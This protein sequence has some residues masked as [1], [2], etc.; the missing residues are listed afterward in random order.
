TAI[1]GL[2][3][4]PSRAAVSRAGPCAGFVL[5]MMGRFGLEHL[6]RVKKNLGTRCYY[7]IQTA[8][9]NAPL[10]AM[11]QASRRTHVL[12]FRLIDFLNVCSPKGLVSSN[13]IRSR[14][15]FLPSP[16]TISA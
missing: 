10:A 1:I 13:V 3:Q 2:V 8:C 14:Y 11:S 6:P 5:T 7:S 12:P 16:E 9:V 4:D 15:T